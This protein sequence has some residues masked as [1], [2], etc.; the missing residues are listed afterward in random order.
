MLQWN[1][2]EAGGTYGT[3]LF[4]LEAFDDSQN[5]AWMSNTCVVP[6]VLI[7]DVFLSYFGGGDKLSEC[8]K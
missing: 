3:L 7:L 6:L 5:E 4:L 8:E 2:K 1:R